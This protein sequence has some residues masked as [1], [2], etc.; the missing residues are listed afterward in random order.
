MKFLLAS[1]GNIIKDKYI[2]WWVLTNFYTVM[3][4]LPVA[5][6]VFWEQAL[7]FGLQSISM[8]TTEEENYGY[9]Q[10]RITRY[11][12]KNIN[13]KAM[14][15]GGLW[16]AAWPEKALMV[17]TVYFFL[18]DCS[19]TNNLMNIE[20]K[21][22]LFIGNLITWNIL[23]STSSLWKFKTSYSCWKLLRIM[24]VNV[25]CSL[26]IGTKTTAMHLCKEAYILSSFHCFSY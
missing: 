9:K 17:P 25:V 1:F 16:D 3:L 23:H 5:F 12:H 22:L 20:M 13:G 18:L 8:S 24:Y 14:Y 11:K 21:T 7:T 6:V 2:K 19:Q 10:G 4:K 15:L 26:S